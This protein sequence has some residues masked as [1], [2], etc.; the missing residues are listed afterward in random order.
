MPVVGLVLGIPGVVV[1]AAVPDVGIMAGLATA[2]GFSNSEKAGMS[3]V[4]LVLGMP[5]V[6]VGPAL[7]LGLVLGSPGVTVGPEV[8]GMV[9]EDGFSDADGCLRVE[10]VGMAVVGLML[11]MPG[12]TVG[13]AVLGVAVLGVAITGGLVT[14]AGVS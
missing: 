2:A 10:E 9:V 1:G 6:P 3:V 5:G 7:V 12:V 13:V 11:G 8:V 4:C 14:A